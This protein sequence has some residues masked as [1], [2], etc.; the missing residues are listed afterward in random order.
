MAY[1]QTKYQRINEEA[2]TVSGKSALVTGSTSGIGLAIAKCLAS[3]GCKVI[4]HGS[5]EKKD[6]TAAINEVQSRNKEIPIH[7]IQTDLKQ[8]NGAEYLCN[9]IA[10]LTLTGQ[11]SVWLL[12]A[13]TLERYVVTDT[14]KH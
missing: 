12:V 14:A 10:E 11:I 2:N 6:A 1:F 3:N 9:E 13:I 4:L 5:R 7:Y 8:P